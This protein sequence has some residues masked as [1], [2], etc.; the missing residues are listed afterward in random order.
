MQEPVLWNLGQDGDRPLD[1][2]EALEGR[3]HR[4]RPPTELG[5]VP[6]GL[7]DLCGIVTLTFADVEEGQVVLGGRILGVFVHYVLGKVEVFGDLYW[8]NE[9]NMRGIFLGHESMK[10]DDIWGQTCTVVRMFHSIEIPTM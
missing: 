9:F 6:P 2:A 7:I 5:V 3:G 1:L 4:P 10:T 8:E